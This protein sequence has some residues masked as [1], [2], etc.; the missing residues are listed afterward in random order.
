MNRRHTAK[1]YLSLVEKIR[2]AKP[3][4]ALSSDFIVG[5]PNETDADFRETMALVETVGYS[6]AYS[7][8]YSARPGTPAARDEN[9]VPEG[10]KAER[11]AELQAL[12]N[13][14]QKKFNETTVGKTLDVLFE[15][16]GKYPGQV[17]GRSPYLQ[18]VHVSLGKNTKQDYAGASE[19]NEIKAYIGQLVPVEIIAAS[20]NSLEGKL[21][22]IPQTRSAA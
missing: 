3:D 6:Q 1:H 22:E 19:E 11:L 2:A 5:F 13:A 15:R 12:L 10:V 14:Q 16:N 9:Q 18:A 4:I 17:V 20:Q 21:I 8:K 7:F